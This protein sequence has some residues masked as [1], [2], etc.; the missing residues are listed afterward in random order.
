MSRRPIVEYIETSSKYIDIL[1]KQAEHY[2]EQCK[3]LKHENK[4]LKEG[5]KVDAVHD[6]TE[7]KL[8]EAAL[9]KLSRVEE[10]INRRT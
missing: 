1:D 10:N 6:E 8:L 5:S 9:K 7:Q 2:Y 4:K 3:L